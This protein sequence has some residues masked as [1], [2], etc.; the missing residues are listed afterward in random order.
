MLKIKFIPVLLLFCTFGFAQVGINST[1]PVATLDIVASQVNGT[2]AEGVI[3]PRLTGEQIKAANSFYTSAQRGA[4][5]YATAAIT[6]AD[7]SGKT[8]AITIP[9]LYCFNGTIWQYIQQTTGSALFLAQLGVVNSAITKATITA[10]GFNTVPLPVVTKNIGGGVWDATN[11]TYQVPFSGTYLIKTSVRLTDFSTSRS[12]FQAVHTSNVDIADGIWQT[13]PSG[14]QR[15]TMLYN[16]IAYFN[17]GDL[18][19]L[20]IYSDGSVANL[21]DASLNIVLLSQ[22]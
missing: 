14:Q 10:T 15:Y 16:R 5:V 7:A 2:T 4:I 12:L 18:L 6:S 13:N 11:N 3:P 19:R 9:G 20:Y 22:N 17:A 21:S 8:T 1:N